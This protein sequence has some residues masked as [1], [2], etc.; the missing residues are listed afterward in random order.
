MPRKIPVPIATYEQVASPDSKAVDAL[1]DNLFA[2]LVK[3]KA[4]NQKFTLQE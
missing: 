1:F 3:A 2:R 4:T